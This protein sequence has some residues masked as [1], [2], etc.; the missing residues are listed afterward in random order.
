MK[1]AMS[2]SKANG[3]WNPSLG[4]RFSPSVEP[5][6]R[7]LYPRL[8]LSR[9]L[10]TATTSTSTNASPDEAMGARDLL[11]TRQDMFGRVEPRMLPTSVAVG[12]VDIA[13]EMLDDD[14]AED[15]QRA[16]VEK[17]GTVEAKRPGPPAPVDAPQTPL[18]FNISAERFHVAR[19]AAVGEADSFWSHTLYQRITPAGA[20]ERVK[21][22]YCTS[23]HSM[24]HV[25]RKYFLHEGLLGFDLEWQTYANRDSDIRSAISLVQIASESR[26]GLFH[27]AMF[28]SAAKEMADF[29]APTFRLIMEDANVSKVG[30]QIQGDCTRL[31]RFLGVKARG[32]FELSHLYKL[33]KYQD[34][35]KLINK[36]PV[37]LS[38]QVEDCLG[39]PLYKGQS[40][41]S[42]NWMRPLDSKQMLCA[43][44]IRIDLEGPF[45]HI[46]VDSAS[47]AYAGVQLYHVLEAKRRALKPCPPR[48]YHAELGLPIPIPIP[49]PTQQ[50]EL[51]P[52]EDSSRDV[53]AAQTVASTPSLART[54]KP[55]QPASPAAK[56]RDARITA[57]EIEMKRFRASKRTPIATT[58]SALRAYYVWRLN[59]D[60]GPEAVA[61]LL[62]D[63]PLQSNTVVSYILDAITA[64]KLPYDK[65]RLANEITSRLQPG[66]LTGRYR[67][68][69]RDHA[70]GP[71]ST[72]EAA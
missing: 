1:R 8:D 68:F 71:K 63:P 18:S 21:V 24:E 22:H 43:S 16:R 46:V 67:H 26:I 70:S 6:T 61:K 23:R 66:P 33:V 17:D 64:E 39:L 56:P 57:A 34:T 53:S 47:D 65:K 62:R 28:P 40:V 38:T 9:F 52:T 32:V 15:E 30:V 2:S 12:P 11:S 60:L 72:N 25:C 31:N 50:S 3:L 5:K 44:R 7:A 10:H 58:P 48:P 19:A 41:R 59:E 13:R 51:N 42:S 14:A 4:I 20:V 36:V 49:I 69:S 27:I 55:A 29:V 45:A 54:K 37:A 35:P